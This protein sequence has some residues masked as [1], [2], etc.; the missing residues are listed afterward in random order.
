MQ[1]WYLILIQSNR[2]SGEIKMSTTVTLVI[3][4]FLNGF[5]YTDYLSP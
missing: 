1:L 2:F 4:N 5:Q 3:S